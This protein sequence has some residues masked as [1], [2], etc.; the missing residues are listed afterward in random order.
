VD[1]GE[2][3]FRHRPDRPARAIMPPNN[4][5]AAAPGG[6]FS[7]SIRPLPP[8]PYRSN[9]RHCISFVLFIARTAPGPA[10]G[11]SRG[12]VT[13]TCNSS[14]TCACG[15]RCEFDEWCFHPSLQLRAT[16][17]PCPATGNRR[18]G[19]VMQSNG[20]RSVSA[21]FLARRPVQL[22]CC[23]VFQTKLCPPSL[24]IHPHTGGGGCARPELGGG[25]HAPPWEMAGTEH[26]RICTLGLKFQALHVAVGRTPGPIL[27]PFSSRV[28]TAR[29]TFISG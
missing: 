22:P 9:T 23:F 18:W 21:R 27:P 12:T 7:Y 3:D 10:A 20:L 13:R 15:R 8:F 26:L 4:A 19:W 29:R 11:Q 6:P 2:R 5:P 16:P 25:R 1:V 17:A 28:R 14:S 24:G